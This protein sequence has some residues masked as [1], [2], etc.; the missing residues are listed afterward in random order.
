MLLENFYLT[1]ISSSKKKIFQSQNFLLEIS[2]KKISSK[3]FLIKIN[4]VLQKVPKEN[5]RTLIRKKRKI[6]FKVFYR[7]FT[8]R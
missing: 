6:S 1:E 7:K 3:D 2:Q 4:F 8:K 5:K